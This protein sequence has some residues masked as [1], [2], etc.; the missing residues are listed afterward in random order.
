MKKSFVAAIT[1]MGICTY[2]GAVM[3]QTE[4]N[5]SVDKNGIMSVEIISD[6]DKKQLYT[7]YFLE[8]NAQLSDN[9]G[10]SVIEGMLK[11]EQA[12]LIPDE[13][14]R[15]NK[16]II[17]ADVS[18]VGAGNVCKAVI[19]GG[20][21]TAETV[22]AVFPDE[23]SAQSALSALG[24]ITQTNAG[25]VLSEHQNKA[26][27]V[28]LSDETYT[29]YQSEVNNSFAQLVKE[30]NATPD[31]VSKLFSVALDLTRLKKCTESEVFDTI[32][33]VGQKTNE[34]LS[35]EILAEKDSI[36]K[37]F[38]NLRADATL[39]PLYKI[40]DF[41]AILRKS[42]AIGLLN[43]ATRDNLLSILQTYNDVF[44]LDFNGAY[45][46]VDSY[47]VV[48]KMVVNDNPY[49]SVADVV[50]RFN[51]AVASL[52]KTPPPTGGGGGGGGGSSSGGSGG[53]VSAPV[54]GSGV[55]SEMV[56]SVDK[57]PR[58]TDIEEASWAKPYII[59]MQDRG[60][61][62]GDGDGR[63]RPND[64]VKR[65]EFLK[66]L[67]E[68][69]KPE[70]VEE[71]IE[72]TFTD[73]DENQWYMKYIKTAVKYKIVN[74]IDENTFGIGHQITR[75]DAAVMIYRAV[76]A[77]QKILNEQVMEQAFTDEEKISDYAQN[78]IKTM[79]KAQII[80]GYDSGE[81]L[82]LNPVTRAES[83]KLIYSVL[84]NINEL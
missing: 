67:I 84:K 77:E 12:E 69:M 11:L 83:A 7:V 73:T 3:A 31:D 80:S 70:E 38:V 66:I 81:F 59:Y 15:Y 28:D 57:T 16:A 45:T 44:V 82:P 22:K 1:A 50:S 49:T 78:P 19:G 47:E 9:E 56:E 32:L 18:A 21:L 17:R 25:A 64:S 72:L 71:D 29:Q 75:Q 46:R 33:S 74:G 13:E 58:F 37:A 51:N 40:S 53:G 41:K 4:I 55:T 5:A 76:E 43:D 39:N 54:S 62:S 10:T 35:T 6:A 52:L 24:S 30:Q 20:E 65:E 34:P 63:V 27:T 42:E 68:A 60:I 79:Q 48:K 8:E 26:W 14:S 61:I 23:A 36:A 2:A